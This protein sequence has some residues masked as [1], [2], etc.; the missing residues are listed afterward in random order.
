MLNFLKKSYLQSILKSRIFSI[1]S[2]FLLNI[3]TF[4]LNAQVLE[5][6]DQEFL[7]GLPPS[8][9]D[10]IEVKN[11]DKDEADLEQLFRTDSSVEKNKILLK[12]LYDQLDAMKERFDAN[13]QKKSENLARFGDSFF[14]S[15]QSSFMPINIPNMASEYIVDVG[16]KFNIMLTGNSKAQSDEYVQRDGTIMIPEV[17]KI[18]IAGKTLS[19]AIESIEK[20]SAE[21]AI[22]AM[23]FVALTEVRDIQILMMGGI[24]SPGIYTISGGSSILSAL[25][26]AGGISENGSFRKIEHRRNGQVLEN[27]DLYDILIF[28]KHPFFGNLRSGDTVFVH[29][30]SFHVPVTGGVANSAIFE[31]LPGETIKDALSFAGGLSEGF[32]GFDSIFLNRVDLSNQESKTVSLNDAQAIKLKPRDSILVPSYVSDRKTMKMVTLNGEVNRPG[33]YFIGDNENLGSLIKRAGG[34]TKNAY[35]FG[36]ALFRVDALNLEKYFAQLNYSDTVNYIV[37][38]VGKPNSSIN[39]S[40]LDLLAEELRSKPLSGRI[41]TNFD[42]DFDTINSNSIVLE[43]GD[44]LIIPKM[45]KVVY[46]FGD[47]KQPSNQE[48]INGASVSDYINLAGGL[49]ESA[50]K[51]VIVIDPDGKTHLHS[52]KRLGRFQENIDLYPGSII[53]APRDIGKISGLVYAS[54]VSPIISSL[55]LSIASLNSIS[56]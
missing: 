34:Y 55:A 29:P 27:V 31:I 28:G 26:V 10:S 4:N 37:S 20:Y 21:R 33:T 1:A 22:G 14:N 12:K 9:R 53:Y 46:M 16:D 15:I 39:S 7:E 30:S 48:F 51:E 42:L 38:N 6:L 54:A 23:P 40:A 3:L 35:V 44:K 32:E 41:I 24:D 56:N 50:Y 52:L 36:S 2:F 17:G 13:D 45:Q 8:L 5:S 43:D 19:D 47:F 18:F 11:A 25:N 49:K